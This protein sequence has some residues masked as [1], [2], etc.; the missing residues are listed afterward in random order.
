M[1]VRKPFANVIHCHYEI[2]SAAPGRNFNVVGPF[3][4]EEAS[5]VR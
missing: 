1:L 2:V 5:D 4:V 3:D